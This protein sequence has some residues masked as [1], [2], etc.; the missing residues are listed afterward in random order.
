M[1]DMPGSVTDTAL[2]CDAGGARRVNPLGLLSSTFWLPFF[3]A[4]SYLNTNKLLM[5]VTDTRSLS[6]A[7][8]QLSQKGK[9][10]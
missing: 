8:S 6:M 2:I 1:W 4:H 9:Y 10:H 3:L 7:P 5:E